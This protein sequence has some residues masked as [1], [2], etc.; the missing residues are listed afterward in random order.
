MLEWLSFA[1]RRHYLERFLAIPAYAVRVD[2]RIGAYAALPASRILPMAY[3]RCG[4]GGVA[5]LV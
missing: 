3:C 4:V 1:Q 2:M 5:V